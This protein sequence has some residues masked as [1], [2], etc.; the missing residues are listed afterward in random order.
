MVVGANGVASSSTGLTVVEQPV[1][2]VGPRAHW[3]C[4]DEPLQ[5]L[6]ES[7]SSEDNH[8][9]YTE[10]SVTVA[11]PLSNHSEYTEHSVTVAIPSGYSSEQSQ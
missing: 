5:H 3:T 10:H 4:S 9:E 1:V 11:I 8:S 7:H 2:C 6:L